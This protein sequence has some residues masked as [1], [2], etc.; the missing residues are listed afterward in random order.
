VSGTTWVSEALCAP[1]RG[2]LPGELLVSPLPGPPRGHCC[3]RWPVRLSSPQL[4]CSPPG[5]HGPGLSVLLQQQRVLTAQQM[6][7]HSCPLPCDGGMLP[8]TGA[9]RSL[10]RSEWQEEAVCG[11]HP[12][13]LVPR[14]RGSLAPAAPLHGVPHAALGNAHPSESAALAFADPP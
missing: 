12:A 5:D 11:E 10:P 8:G 9:Q 3:W 13:L 6:G 14:G 4:P 2:H 1:P 7:W